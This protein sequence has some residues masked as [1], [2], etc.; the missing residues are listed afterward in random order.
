MD[1]V[2]KKWTS[3]ADLNVEC[4]DL[5]VCSF[6]DRFLYKFGGVGSNDQLNE[7]IEKLDYYIFKI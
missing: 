1:V 7:Y 3:I 2:T 5:S 4:R 6:N